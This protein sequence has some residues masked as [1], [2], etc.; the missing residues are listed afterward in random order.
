[1]K[2]EDQIGMKLNDRYLKVDCETWHDLKSG[3]IF[4]HNQYKDTKYGKDFNYLDDKKNYL[5][6]QHG[7]LKLK[8][9]LRRVDIPLDTSNLQT[10][11]EI[12]IDFLKTNPISFKNKTVL[13]LGGGPSTNLVNWKKIKFDTLIACNNFIKN[14]DILQAQPSLVSFAPF[15]DLTHTNQHLHQYIKDVDCTITFEP[16]HIKKPEE[17]QLKIFYKEYMDRIFV[18]QTRYSS[19]LGIGARQII[20]SILLG[21]K[22]IYFTGI[23]LHN[24]YENLQHAYE[25]S[26]SMPR[27]RLMYGKDLQD[28][29]VIIFFDYIRQL[30]EIYNF[31]IVNLSQHLDCNKS[32]SFATKKLL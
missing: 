20:L 26:K 15:V 21:A 23:D 17:D 4:H 6:G 30:R 19:C 13:I 22:K 27:W 16:E 9:F 12:I 18:F 29:Q 11:D 3:K 31:E 28:R 2:C 14:K 5:N 8:K 1:M 32:V 7:I 25:T 10:N 24:D